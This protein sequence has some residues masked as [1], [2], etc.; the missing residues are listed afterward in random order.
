[1]PNWKRKPILIPAACLALLLLILTLLPVL[2]R[3]L[4]TD[5]LHEHGIPAATI[6]NV[7]LNLFNGTFAIDDVKAGKG[8]NIGRLSAD[9]DW[10]PLVHG[11]L[12]IRSIELRDTHLKLVQRQD[13]WLPVGLTLPAGE[14]ETQTTPSETSEVPLQ[15]IL[16]AIE[17][18]NIQIE[19]EGKTLKLALPL[20]HLTLKLARLRNDG[21]QQL[22]L[23][24]QTGA[25]QF[26]GMGYAADN[27]GVHLQA[28]IDLPRLDETLPE[29]LAATVAHA[30]LGLLKLS[31]TAH[32]AEASVE[33]IDINKARWR[34]NTLTADSVK[35]GNTKLQGA[36]G[37]IAIDSVNFRELSSKPQRTTLA[38]L[39]IRGI[40]SRLGG[41]DGKGS[42]ADIGQ[43]KATTFSID[44][45]GATLADLAIAD[46]DIRLLR[47]R[48]GK[49]ALPATATHPDEK[50]AEQPAAAT[51]ATADT[52]F[53]LGIEKLGIASGSRFSMRDESVKPPFETGMS[54]EQ[55]SISPIHWPADQP[56]E[57]DLRLKTGGQG[58]LTV[59]GTLLPEPENPAA[60]LSL[61]VKS[62]DMAQLSRY[63]EAHFGQAIRTGQM[64]VQSKIKIANRQIDAG[65]QL[66]FRKLVLKPAG[67]KTGGETN[68]LGMPLDMALDMLR[69][70]RGDIALKVPVSGKIDDPDINLND[71]INQALMSAI[72]AGALQY[73]AQL[74]QPYGSLLTAAKLVGKVAG[75]AAKPR[76]TPVTFAG[77]SAD[78]SP[79]M[80]AYTDKVAKLLKAKPFRLEVCGIATRGEAGPDPKAGLPRTL[81]DEALLKLAA[82]RSGK[83]IQ[84]LGSQGVEPERLF[85]CRDRLDEGN[86]AQPRV[87]LILD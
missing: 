14:P 24:L 77:Q 35:V 27:A 54:V 75:E 16:H 34:D 1:M 9:F 59:K 69:D 6:R 62:L 68:E 11:Q 64:D 71:A 12:A 55:F 39:D 70:G 23:A 41:Q 57:I 25:M 49:L 80:Q 48:D 47:N 13:G 44:N 10:W 65:N 46:A 29:K 43:L 36:P 4:A 31:D 67:E 15:P 40:R 81:N 84:R 52:P 38:G 50:T 60:N 3:H 76:L 19:A 79:Q 61:Q 33:R 8:L 7:D 42:Q 63:A 51:S 32:H 45:S 26:R 72:Q 87:E 21:S 28:E 82:S 83:V 66:T 18:R 58:T 53:R 22:A 86:K 37:T 73:A 78:L 85:H 56:S 74:L 30:H 17:L 5:W 20:E 2:I